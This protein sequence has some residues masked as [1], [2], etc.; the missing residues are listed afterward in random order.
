MDWLYSLEKKGKLNLIDVQST[1]LVWVSI[2]KET[3]VFME[4][5]FK[6]YHSIASR[7]IFS[8]RSGQML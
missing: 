5:H 1:L 2:G 8:I 7:R 4:C 6:S 3:M